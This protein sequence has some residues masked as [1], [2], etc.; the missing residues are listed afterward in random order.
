MI[1]G[2][3][4][5]PNVLRLS[6]CAGLLDTLSMYGSTLRE[7]QAVPSLYRAVPLLYRRRTDDSAHNAGLYRLVRLVHHF[8][9]QL[10]DIIPIRRFDTDI[11]SCTF[12]AAAVLNFVA[13]LDI[14]LAVII[15]QP[16]IE[17]L[18]SECGHAVEVAPV[19]VSII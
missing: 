2:V 17:A 12:S 7:L 8:L 5:V 9:I 11:A 4:A 14:V 1:F 18:T 16:Q 19:A 10:R 3:L 13:V 6:V 15:F